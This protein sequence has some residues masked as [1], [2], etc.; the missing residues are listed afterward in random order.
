MKMCPICEKDIQKTDDKFMVAL[1]KPYLNVFF[2]RECYLLI[3]SDLLN[4]LE[5]VILPL[6][7]KKMV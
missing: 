2:H 5:K 1:D 3:E 6:F 7:Y 4:M